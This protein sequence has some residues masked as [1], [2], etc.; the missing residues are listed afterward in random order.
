LL[1]EEARKHYWGTDPLKELF[2][3]YTEQLAAK[4]RALR[5][6]AGEL[7]RVVLD[8]GHILVNRR[9]NGRLTI[10]VGGGAD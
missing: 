8:V 6:S 2:E 10:T 1:I 5:R 4:A 9:P 3:T 7:D